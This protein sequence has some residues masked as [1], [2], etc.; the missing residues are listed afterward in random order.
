MK[1]YV[2]VLLI[3]AFFL[4]D[5]AAQQVPGTVIAHSPASDKKYLGS[6]S[7][8]IL[9]SGNYV[10]SHD[11]FG[12]GSTAPMPVLKHNGRDIIFISHTAYDDGLGGAN[13][14]HDANYV[15]FLRLRNYIIF[16]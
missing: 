11:F 15:T 9:P 3:S 7:I 16:L 8:C 10:A 4:S 5:G 13:N 14:Q 6:P 12:P 1:K 2:L